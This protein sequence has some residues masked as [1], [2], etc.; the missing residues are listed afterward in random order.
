MA[1]FHGESDVLALLALG[2]L[3]LSLSRDGRV[4]VRAAAGAAAGLSLALAAQP[5][6]LD[7]ASAPA[8]PPTLLPAGFEPT[9]WC[10][11]DAYLNKVLVGSAD[12]RLCLV[13]FAAGRVVHTFDGWGAPVR[14]L[15][16]SPA[17]DVVGAGLG[18]GTI[19]LHNIRFDAPVAAFTHDSGGAAVTSL[20]FRTG[21]GLP[22]LAAGGAGGGQLSV[23]DL[24]GR[25]LHT[26]VRDAHGGA[27]RPLPCRSRRAQA[28]VID[29]H[30]CR[31]PA[32][33]DGAH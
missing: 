32:R 29:T 21:P 15:T 1:T 8:H 3:V 25:R 12:G 4:T 30:Q 11:P 20:S 23:W 14:C 9:C 28:A 16:A 24:E 27:V 10:H 22:L 5:W 31:R 17:L 6:S 26:V 7:D 33:G 18:D 2:D 13:N 19:R